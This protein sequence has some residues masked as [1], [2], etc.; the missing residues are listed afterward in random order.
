MHG[1][2]VIRWS[3]RTSHLE[4]CGL[5]EKEEML[6]NIPSPRALEEETASLDVSKSISQ[7]REL[8]EIVT[9]NDDTF[10]SFCLRTNGGS[11]TW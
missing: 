10:I 9:A 1:E 2:N 6:D 11:H 3:S 4:P 7:N 8:D 5:R